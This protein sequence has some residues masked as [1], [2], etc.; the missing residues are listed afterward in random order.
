MALDFLDC[1]FRGRGTLA[2]GRR[3]A[4]C[5]LRLKCYLSLA[6]GAPEW[7]IEKFRIGKLPRQ[8]G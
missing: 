5:F 2:L 6:R 3:T 1:R 7:E 8:T 4:G